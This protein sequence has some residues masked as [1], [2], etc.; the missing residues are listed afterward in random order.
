MKLLRMA[1]I[2]LAFALPLSA[3]QTGTVSGTVT[4]EGSGVTGAQVVLSHTETGAQY[5]AL[6][7]TGG[8]Y[9]VT[10][11]PAGSYN[12]VVRMIGFSA[13]DEELSVRSGETTTHD[14]AMVPSALTLGS[15]EVLA[16]RAEPRKTPVA[17]SDVSKAQIQA[18]LGSRDLPLVLNVT[19]SVY[20]TVQGGGAGDARVNVR[21]FSQRNTAVMINGVPV[22]DMENGWVYWSNWDG[23]GDAATSIQLQRGLSAINLATPSI[24][25]TL[26]VITDP[27]ARNPGY[28]LKQEFGSGNF[29]KTTMTASTGPV[30]DFALTASVARKTGDGIIDGT[31]TDAWSFYLASQYRMGDRNRLEFYALGAP[32]RHGHNLYKLNIATLNREFAASLDDYDPAALDR[33]AN[34]AGRFWNPNFNGVD[35][36][37]SGRQFT[38]T[39]PGNGVFSRHSRNFI[40]ERENYFHKPQVNLNWYSNLGNGLTANTVAYYSGGKGGGTGTFGSLRW[41]YTY[42]QRFA[43]WNATIDRNSGSNTGSF[44]IL[45][46]SVNNQDTWGFITRLHKE[47]GGDLNTELGIDWRT[48]T[49]EHYREVRDLLGGD[50]FNG[51]F[52][53]N[54][55]SDFWTEADANRGLGDKIHYHNENDVNWVGVHLQAE[56]SSPAGSFYGMVGWSRNAYNFTDF[57][58]KGPGDAPLELTSGGL[59]GYQIKGGAVR[60]MGPEWSVYGNAGV[61]SKVPIF[62]GAIDDINGLLIDNPQNE[63]FLS[64]E[65]G[66]RF[67]S[68]GR[69][70]SLDA[71]LYFTQWNDRTARRFARD[72]FGEG[73]D[74]VIRMLGMDARHMGVELEAAFQ[75]SDFMRFDGALSFGDWKHT[76]NIQGSYS[77]EDRQSETLDYTFFVKDLLVG[78]APQFQ[79]AYALSLFP[80]G[81]LYVRLQGKTFGK[82][83]ANFDPFSRTT[84]VDAGVQSWRP[85]GYSVFDF[86]VSYR[87]SDEMSAPFG[88][89]VRLFIHG[90]NMFDAIYIQDATDNSRF[91]GYRDS[92]ERERGSLSHKADD[93]EVYLGYPRN[94][95]F[96][97]Q[98]Y[99]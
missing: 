43:D 32:Q 97:F 96:G 45:R 31:W 12:V 1:P 87:L 29:L 28:N 47:F 36:S 11:V 60:N 77:A 82:H 17:Y 84:D 67:R 7:E 75:P 85:P 13:E 57:F 49:I 10:D 62:D 52:R 90:Y 21:G 80:S 38:S 19:P 34:E 89:N 64:F 9:S 20:S 65:T 26:N 39:G 15:L 83:Y 66:T 69:R 68:L 3:Q 73:D 76:D 53:G 46:N 23:L 99:H 74:A 8:R 48:A 25:G 16:D 35:P 44:G 33:F 93:A 2:L 40:N 30:G 78:D 14:V 59:T 27:S 95:N 22:N 71:N 50:Y 92:A 98:I 37:Y 56:K 88:G 42:G 54:C 41:D 70:F 18:Q 58:T 81:G 86:H 4:A 72:F 63:T 55:H 79:M 6:T 51:C 94:F 61:V 24:G 5:G 91:N